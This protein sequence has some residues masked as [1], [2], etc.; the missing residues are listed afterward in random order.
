MYVVI[1]G[2]GQVGTQIAKV[3][4]DEGHSVAMIESD[5]GQLENLEALDVLA[6]EGNAASPKALAEAGINTAD[7]LVAATGSD[8]VNIIASVVAK[9]KGCKT[10]TRI[11]SPDYIKEGMV[12]GSLETF[13]IDVAVCPDMVTATQVSKMLLMPTLVESGDL[14]EGKAVV[15]EIRLDH[16]SGALSRMPSSIDLPDG[17]VIGSVSR[18][19]AVLMPDVC[20]V[21]KEEDRVILALESK[22]LLNQVEKAFGVTLGEGKQVG[23]RLET[24][25]QKLIIVGATRMGIQVARRLEGSRIVVLIDRDEASCTEAT[26]QLNKTLVINGDATDVELLQEESIDDADALV[27]MT[28]SS[29]FNMLSCLLAKRRGVHKTMA[30]VDDPELRQLFEQIGISIAL[31]PRLM[32]VNTILQH[33][34]GKATSSTMTT[35]QGSGARV[36]EILVTKSLWMVGREYGSIRFPKSAYIGAVIRKEKVM[37]PTKFDVVKPGDRL[38]IFLGPEALRKVEKMFMHQSKHRL[39]FM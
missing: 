16:G 28:E 29:E 9:S 33:I 13:G 12:T 8:E 4:L 1:A 32:T 22:H 21:F 37:V 2:A 18:F 6:I 20:G 34:S 17:A 35:L 14:A 7:L 26:T 5:K 24:G 39:P 23:A 25:M 31:S 19:G 36:L 11:S 27:A 15:V 30:I 10:V 38:I 3:L